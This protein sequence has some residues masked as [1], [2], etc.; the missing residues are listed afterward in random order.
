MKYPTKY[1]RY[2]FKRKLKRKLRKIAFMIIVATLVGG[3]QYYGKY[4]NNKE[5]D[6]TLKT[7]TRL[8]TPSIYKTN[9][10]ETDPKTLHKLEQAR[11][12]PNAKLWVQVR[13]KVSKLLKDDLHGSRHQKF[14]I[15]IDNQDFTLLVAHNIDLAK[16]VPVVVGDSVILYGLYEWNNRGGIIHWTHHDPKGKKKG[17]WIRLDKQLYH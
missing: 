6:Q 15:V 14:L 8:N 17:G 11:N 1:R 10:F 7:S 9:T 12:N 2:P 16:R 4:Y 3:T 13:G 5:L